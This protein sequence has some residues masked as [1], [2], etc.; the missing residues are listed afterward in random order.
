MSGKL[1]A[2]AVAQHSEQR[3]RC[4]AILRVP[5]WP[6]LQMSLRVGPRHC[7]ISFAFVA[8]SSR[9]SVAT[10]GANLTYRSSFDSPLEEDGCELPVPRHSKLS[11]R[12]QG[13]R[14]RK[15]VRIR[16]TAGERWIRTCMGLF[17]SSSCFGLLPVLCS[18][19]GKAVLRPV[20]CD[21]V[22]GARGRGQGT[23]T[24]AKLGGLC[25]LSGACVS[26]RLDA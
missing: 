22:R 8:Y 6:S 16:L 18:E 25:R 26:Q 17:L 10:M 15:S 9:Q 14:P 20:A 24:V 3:G 2:G 12:D 23:E 21:Q 11:D 4:G 7:S 19:R 1:I 5:A 13:M